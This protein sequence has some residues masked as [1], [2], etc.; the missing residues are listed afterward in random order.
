MRVSADPEEGECMQGGSQRRE[1]TLLT[2]LTLLETAPNLMETRQLD[3][4]NLLQC[5]YRDIVELLVF[6]CGDSSTVLEDQPECR[7]ELS[8]NF[9]HLCSKHGISPSIR[10]EPLQQASF[11]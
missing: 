7:R 5:S 8:R 11:P 2:A 1:Q 4:E 10:L 6:Q 3:R 9:F